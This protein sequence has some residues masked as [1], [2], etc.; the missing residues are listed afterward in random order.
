MRL[1]W[2][3]RGKQMEVK[4]YWISGSVCCFHV[5]FVFPQAGFSEGQGSGKQMPSFM[6]HS[7]YI[8]P[9]TKKKKRKIDRK[10]TSFHLEGSTNLTLSN[11]FDDIMYVWLMSQ[12]PHLLIRVYNR[13]Y[14]NRDY[15]SRNYNWFLS[16]TVITLPNCI[17]CQFGFIN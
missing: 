17:T 3:G 7:L 11:S 2:T 13:D 14:N 9:L 10:L 6:C 8:K 5:Y 12:L 1:I 15:N 16:T 4:G